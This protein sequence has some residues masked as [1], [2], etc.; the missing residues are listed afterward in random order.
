MSNSLETSISVLRREFDIHVDSESKNYRETTKALAKHETS[1]EGF[2]DFS[3][4]LK[5]DIKW[6][7]R[8]GIAIAILVSPQAAEIIKS[9]LVK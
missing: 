2:H 4:E 3:R 6:I 1:I 8:I 7:K 9:L 5:L